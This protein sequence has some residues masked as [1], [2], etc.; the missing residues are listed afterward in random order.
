VFPFAG[1]FSKDIILEAAWAA[2]T[3]VGNYAFWLGITAAFLTA[4][5]SW[6]LIIMT[7]HGK[8]R[9]DEKTMAHVHESPKVMILPLLLL[10]AGACFA[11]WGAYEWFVGH[12][13][14]HFWGNAILVLPAHSA[15]EDAHHVPA[16][17]KYLPLVV[18]GAGIA[19]A[20][21][22]YMFVPS[23]PGKVV[24]AIKPIH[25][26]VFN[27]WYFDELFDAV[28]VKP[29]FAI[30]K[31]F[32]KVGDQQIIDGLGPNGIAHATQETAQKTG[33]LQT[34]YLYHYAFAMLIG[35]VLMVTWYMIVHVG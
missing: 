34:G 19:L 4:F 30:G 7:F 10:A 6:R 20:Y 29:C 26:F 14:E 24:Q 18:G 11:G 5:Y 33:V 21:V 23:L 12:G 31:G 32:W 1:Y 13:A 9:A 16:W 25:T 27:K 35:V 17:V 22:M 15:L 2:H 3:S 28:F 8:P